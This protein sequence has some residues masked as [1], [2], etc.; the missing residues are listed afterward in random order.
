[1]KPPT[2]TAEQ[3]AQIA[4]FVDASDAV[5][6]VTLAYQNGLNTFDQRSINRAASEALK[7]LIHAIDD[8]E[9][10]V[11]AEYADGIC[12]ALAPVIVISVGALM[13]QRLKDAG[14]GGGE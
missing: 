9:P 1:M 14:K 11:R 10:E 8:V 7:S 6:T 13:M 4:G 3:R 5:R 12:E 2:T